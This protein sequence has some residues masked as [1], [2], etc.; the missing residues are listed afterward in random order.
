VRH[1]SVDAYGVFLIVVEIY[2]YIVLEAL[3]FL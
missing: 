1:G 2:I 3:G